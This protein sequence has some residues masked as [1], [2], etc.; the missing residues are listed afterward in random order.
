M[1]QVWDPNWSIFWPSERL[2]RFSR[3]LYQ[4]LMIM[5]S[6]ELKAEKEAIT[7]ASMCTS[8]VVNVRPR[9]KQL[10]QEY[11]RVVNMQRARSQADRM[12]KRADDKP[13][14]SGGRVVKTSAAAK[15][16]NA[17]KAQTMPK[18]GP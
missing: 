4:D 6:R 18:A 2:A 17:V 9:I 8:F 1:G 3:P 15:L 12:A 5:D 7:L 13:R 10:E 11:N 16:Q 14:N